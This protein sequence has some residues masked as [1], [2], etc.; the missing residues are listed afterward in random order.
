MC[1]GKEGYRYALLIKVI[2]PI[3]SICMNFN[4]V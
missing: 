3:G 1:S 4:K 2:G